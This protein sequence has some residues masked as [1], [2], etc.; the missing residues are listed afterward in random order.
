[1]IS[2]R[3]Q[4]MQS[5]DGSVAI[6]NADLWIHPKRVSFSSAPDN[7]ENS[8]DLIVGLPLAEPEEHIGFPVR[9]VPRRVVAQP[10]VEKFFIGEPV[11]FRGRTRMQTTLDIGDVR[12]DQIQNC[13][14]T[15]GKI[16]AV[17]VQAD[18][19]KSSRRFL[20]GEDG[21]QFAVHTERAIENV[22]EFGAMKCAA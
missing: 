19:E 5:S 14:V 9:E 13:A 4:L 1:M 16:S 17:A 12:E 11:C 6:L 8:A 2:R 21:S 15:L 3:R 10:I 7:A 18:K 22:V 20:V